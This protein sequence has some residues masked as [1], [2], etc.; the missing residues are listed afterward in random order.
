MFQIYTIQ[1]VRDFSRKNTRVLPLYRYIF[2]RLL[3]F[4]A[5]YNIE[6]S[7]SLNLYTSQK[8]FSENFLPETDYLCDNWKTTSTGKDVHEKIKTHHNKT[9]GFRFSLK[10][11]M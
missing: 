6:K 8:P 4:H 1:C 3:W 7:T 10:R 2:S 11:K 5:F 9:N